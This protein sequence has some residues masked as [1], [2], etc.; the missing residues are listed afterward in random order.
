LRGHEKRNSGENYAEIK[1]MNFEELK[2][3]FSAPPEK[4]PF[5]K[6]T[7]TKKP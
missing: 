4:N 2:V 6:H 1:G 7:A 5:K 3:Y